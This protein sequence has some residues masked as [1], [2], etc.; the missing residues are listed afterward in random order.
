MTKFT[1]FLATTA[2]AFCTATGAFAADTLTISTWL[3]PTHPVNTGMFTQLSE[4]MSEATNGQI[5][6]E[7][8]NGLA[9]PPAQMDLVLDG[10]ADIAILFHGYTPGRFVGTKLV[11]VPGYEGNAEAASVAHWR[12]HDA[13]L[14][15][16]DEH[17]GVKV[18]AL[19]THGPGQIHSN[20]EVATLD[21]LS[22]LKTRLGGGVSADVGAELGLVGIQVPAPKVYETLDSGAA[23]AVAMNMGERISFKLNEVAKNVYEMPGGFYRGSFSVILS[24]ET[25]DSLPMDVQKAL[26]EKVFGEPASRMMGAVWDQSDV[27]ARSAT[28]AASDNKIVTAS[29]E[30]QE[31]FA[32]MAA[33]V[34][35]K[36]IAEL[37]DSGIDGQAAYEMMRAEMA[38][39]SE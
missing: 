29:A 34:R 2:V 39:A 36:V 4:M 18:I 27:T 35:E 3:P 7:L 5:I 12:V 17:R 9:P 38:K 16:L 11:E 13:M 8:K 28:E 10:A 32:E 24:Q 33:R 1:N 31:R 25:F 21:D 14:A 22:G 19:T 15:Q 6:T 23:D 20:K 37:T 30:D 26:D